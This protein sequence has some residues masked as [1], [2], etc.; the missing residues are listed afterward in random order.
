VIARLVFTS[1]L[2]QINSASHAIQ[3]AINVMDH[4]LMNAL[5]ARPTN[6]FIMEIALMIAPQVFTKI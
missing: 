2:S 1:Q 4:S 5:N 3:I 6:L